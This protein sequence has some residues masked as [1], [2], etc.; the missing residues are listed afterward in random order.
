MPPAPSSPIDPAIFHLL[1]AA[2][3]P[4]QD[5]AGVLA[6]VA[7]GGGPPAPPGGRSPAGPAP[8]PAAPSSPID[9]AICHL[10]AAAPDLEQDRAGVLAVLTGVADPRARRGVRHR[11]AAI[12][13]LAVCAVLAGARSFTAIAEW[14]KDADEAT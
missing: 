11:L 7:G 4:E 8:V 5:R 12:L 3:D 10:L 2:P 9:P 6:G 13:A 14:A 1:P